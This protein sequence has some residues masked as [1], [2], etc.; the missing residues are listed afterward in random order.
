MTLAAI[1]AEYGYAVQPAT[2]LKAATTYCWKCTQ[3]KGP[4]VAYCRMSEQLLYLHMSVEIGS[5]K[6]VMFECPRD[7]HKQTVSYTHLRAH[8][9]SA[10]L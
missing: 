4:W 6:F 3:L 7:A 5:F 8:E 9:T 1:A 10:H 2:A